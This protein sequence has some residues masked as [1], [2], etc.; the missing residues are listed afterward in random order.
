[1]R[2]MMAGYGGGADLVESAERLCILLVS[3]NQ[4]PLFER[5]VGQT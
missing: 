5:K 3:D 1:M 4:G 2:E